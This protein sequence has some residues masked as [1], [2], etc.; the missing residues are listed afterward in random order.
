MITNQPFAQRY[1]DHMAELGHPV[2]MHHWMGGS[3]D[4]GNVS[5][6]V[7]TIH[8]MFSIPSDPMN[9][10]HTAPFTEAA[11]GEEAHARTIRVAKAM[12]R[13]AYDLAADPEL[14][15][16][17]RADFARK[18]THPGDPLAAR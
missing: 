13:A 14:L 17:V 11:A 6:V 10:N 4:M 2:G 3:T 18:V 9:G 12:A 1:C 8:P 16:S 7:P 15:A 5:Y